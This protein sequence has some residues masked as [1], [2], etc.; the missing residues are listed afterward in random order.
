MPDRRRT[1]LALAATGSWPG[2]PRA[3]EFPARPITFIVPYPQGGPAGLIARAVGDAMH[4]RLG[5]PVGLD[6]QPGAT[7]QIAA[8]VLFR[9]P[10]DGHTLLVGD[11][12]TLGFSRELY[13]KLAHDPLVDFEPVAPL[14]SMPMVL[15]VP[16][17]S[18]FRST[19]NLVAA[20]KARPLSY[21][22]QGNGSIGHVLGEMLRSVS[23]GQFSHLPFKGSAPAMAELLAGTVDFLFDGIGPGWPHVAA[24]RIRPLSIAGRHR[25]PQLPKVPTT[26]QEGYP[27]VALS[28]WLGVV[29]RAGTPAPI[30]QRLH[31]EIGLAL[32]QP[33]NAKRFAGLGF[34]PIATRGVA[35]FRAFVKNEAEASAAFI[36][37][38]HLSLD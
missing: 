20:S 24:G 36:R 23:G 33:K 4:E 21:A 26:A 37:S 31:D 28:L 30:V 7:G 35:G 8:E 19:A 11:N 16:K 34:Q 25:L 18:P 14:L 12:T 9:S 38:S 27:D 2:Q 15:Y 6:F 32:R 5:Q 17:A 22:S 29:V 13:K 10:A 3:Q 1:L